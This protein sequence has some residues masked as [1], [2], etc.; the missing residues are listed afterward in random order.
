M[1]QVKIGPR[2]AHCAVLSPAL[3]RRTVSLR[4]FMRKLEQ[5]SLQ[6]AQQIS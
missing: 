3:F 6:A 5:T 2:M 4:N 1:G